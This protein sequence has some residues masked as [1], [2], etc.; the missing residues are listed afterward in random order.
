M[1]GDPLCCSNLSGLWETS[2]NS[3]CRITF[4][5]ISDMP[6]SGMVTGICASRVVTGTGNDVL[7]DHFHGEWIRSRCTKTGNDHIVVTIN[8]PSGTE[9]GNNDVV[10]VGTIAVGS[11]GATPTADIVRVSGTRHNAR[12][13]RSS[14]Q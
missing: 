9:S 10:W 6:V 12:W 3:I 5:C 11:P 4:N 2:C 8:M 7:V 1:K 13:T 14:S